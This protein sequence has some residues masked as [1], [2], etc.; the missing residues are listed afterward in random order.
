M[1]S[2]NTQKP[3]AG[4]VEDDRLLRGQGRFSDDL[5][6]PNIGFACFV[7]SPHAFAKIIGVD[8]AAAKTMPGVL[9]VLT[10]ADILAGDYESV[11]LPYPLDGCK[12]VVAPYRPALASDRVM[13]VGE[14]VAIVIAERLD[15]A[16]DAADRVE[17]KYEALSPVSGTTLSG[18][19]SQ[20]WP[21]APHN[22]ALDY[23]AP[24][25][26]EGD[27]AAKIDQCFVRAAHVASVRL[28][29]Q[30]VAAVSLETRGA[31]AFYDYGQDLFTLRCGSQGVAGIQREVCR[32]MRLPLERLRV[33]S[34]DVGGGFGMKASSYPEYIVL[35]HGAKLLHRPVHWIS[36]RAEA[37]QTD[38]QARDSDWSGELALDENGRFLA[39]RVNVVANIGAYLTGVGHYCV[40]RHVAECL[41]GTYDIP[42]VSLHTRCIFSNSTPVGPYRGAGRPET[43]YFL[44]RLVD[45]ASQSTGI[46]PATLR[47]IN[48]LTPDRLPLTTQFGNTYDSGDFPAIFEK[49]LILADYANFPTRRERSRT[50]GLL[51]GVGIGCYL[52]N[53]GAFPQETARIS[54]AEEGIAVSIG[55]GSTGQGHATVFRTLVAERLGVLP[56][57]ITVSSGDSTRDVPGFGAVASRT[58]MMVG[59]AIANAVDA[60]I[61]KGTDIAALLLQTDRSE[62]GYGFGSFQLKNGQQSLKLIEVATR[63]RELARQAII[64]ESLDT[65][66][67]VNAPASFPNGCHIAEVEI[68]PET[69]SVSLCSYIGVD[70][71]GN[72]LNSTIVEGQFHGGVVQGI[73]QALREAVIYDV[74]TA[75]LVSGSFMDY[76][77]PRASDVPIMKVL[78]HSVTCTTNPLGVKGAGESGTTAAPCAIMN[79]IA[80]ALPPEAS[81][82]LNM[83]ATSERI[84]KALRERS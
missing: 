44:E 29:N 27:S 64:S 43:N 3:W 66:V 73:G 77:V 59:G 57:T 67:T 42:H 68:D 23:Y 7:R 24:P 74:N 46:D 16:Q 4:R 30:R 36:T 51:R 79:A 72:V 40:T 1:S 26:P 71:C 49:A 52:E 14:A 55:A 31:T 5:R 45:T 8:T 54:F 6:E 28:T 81:A 47:R 34:D 13:H 22:I 76:G 2:S 32:A 41:P 37:F 38:N 63:A 56:E 10:G 48:L 65:T 33:L 82:R 69:G 17:V 61:T 15:Q 11:T 62:I 80:S 21:D 60:I 25:D 50:A 70:D 19:G 53:A 58:A 39:L 18:R 78:H 20:L 75:Q 12:S 9:A 83:P 35:L 84:W